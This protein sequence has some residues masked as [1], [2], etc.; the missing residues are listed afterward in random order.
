MAR[1]GVINLQ[2]LVV[3]RVVFAKGANADSVIVAK[4]SNYTVTIEKSGGFPDDFKLREDFT[5]DVRLDFD[6]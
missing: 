5:V 2:S 6:K 4:G 1:N 3:Q